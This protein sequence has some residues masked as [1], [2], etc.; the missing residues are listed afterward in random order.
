[1]RLCHVDNWLG[2]IPQLIA[3][4]DHQDVL[5]R[6]LLHNLLIQLGTRHAQALVFPLSVAIKAPKQER[7]AAAQ[8][9]MSSL[10][11]HSGRIIGIYL[12]TS[13]DTDDESI[14]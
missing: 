2:V 9:L 14:L 8:S 13:F 6:E 7:M 1:M 12:I 5:P 11:Q 10:R 4:I 3:R